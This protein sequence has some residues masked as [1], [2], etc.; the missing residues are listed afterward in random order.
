MREMMRTGGLA[1]LLLACSMASAQE[2]D[3]HGAEVVL[4]FFM[5]MWLGGDSFANNAHDKNLLAWHS[6]KVSPLYTDADADHALLHS[7]QR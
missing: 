4:I 1:L 6:A 7:L 5:A 2:E 3:D